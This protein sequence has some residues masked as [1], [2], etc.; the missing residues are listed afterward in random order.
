MTGIQNPRTQC[1]EQSTTHIACAI[2]CGEKS[3][4]DGR[5][6]SGRVVHQTRPGHQAIYGIRLPHNDLS[7]DCCGCAGLKLRNKIATLIPNQILFL[8]ENC[9][10]HTDRRG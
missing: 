8:H 1:E 4:K 10:L 5:Q 7:R 6:H 3:L 9:I 2:T